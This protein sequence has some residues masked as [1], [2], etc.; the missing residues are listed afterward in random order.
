MTFNL[1][2]ANR[3]IFAPASQLV[4][5]FWII[6]LTNSNGLPDP[7]AI[8]WG[9]SGRAD[10]FMPR[11]GYWLLTTLTL[12]VPWAVQVAVYLAKRK[13]PLTRG[14]LDFVFALVYWLMFFIMF[15]VTI[16]QT[17]VAS[18]FQS[19][20]PAVLV[21]LLFCLI[22]LS[23]WFGLAFP[24]IE[25]GQDLVV[26]MRG[27]RVLSIP[28][29]ELAGVETTRL[30]SWKY[31]GLGVRAAGKTL[32]FI[33]SKGEGVLFTLRSGEQLAIRCHEAEQVANEART[34]LAG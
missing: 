15:S 33:P 3:F 34:K 24:E 2:S 20:F 11:A 19:T 25:L 14:F 18:G 29:G 6:F 10:G 27:L 8:H 30:S 32:A 31:G 28:V 23:L 22:P 26:K 12:F 9:L 21:G 4:F 7:I 16:I 17:S 5:G 13:S 1:A